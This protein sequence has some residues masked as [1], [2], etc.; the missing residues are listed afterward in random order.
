MQN[1]HTSIPAGHR[2]CVYSEHALCQPSEAR[3]DRQAP[4][5]SNSPRLK[6]IRPAR[7]AR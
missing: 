3:R 1:W 6:Q 4:Q 7:N 2:D 5:P